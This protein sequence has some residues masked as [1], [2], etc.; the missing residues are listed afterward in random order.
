[1]CLVSTH[2]H[3]ALQI[4]ITNERLSDEA[5]TYIRTYVNMSSHKWP[6]CLIA[7][8]VPAKDLDTEPIEEEKHLGA[9]SEGLRDCQINN[10]Q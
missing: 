9:R 7:G 3:F 10:S 6:T 4:A 5:H 1:M 2:S 8:D